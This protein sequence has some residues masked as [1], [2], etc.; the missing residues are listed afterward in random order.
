[1]TAGIKTVKNESVDFDRIK[2]LGTEWEVVEVEHL[3][4][5]EEIWG[6]TASR[7]REIRLDPDA[8]QPTTLVHEIY[9]TIEQALAIQLS[10]SE[11]DHPVA[12]QLAKGFVSVCI[13][14]VDFFDWFVKK[15]KECRV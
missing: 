14:N 3:V 9:H 5:D 6:D 12:Q 13:E 7:T 1:M 8:D 10:E 15:V 4:A 2:V 11:D